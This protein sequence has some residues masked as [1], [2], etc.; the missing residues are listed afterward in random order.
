MCLIFMLNKLLYNRQSLT[1]GCDRCWYS[2]ATNLYVK[3]SIDII[4][5]SVGTQKQLAQ[6]GSALYLLKYKQADT[7]LSRWQPTKDLKEEE[8]SEEQRAVKSSNVY[9]LIHRKHCRMPLTS[10]YFS[11]E[12][13]LRAES[14]V[15]DWA[16]RYV[17][18]CLYLLNCLNGELR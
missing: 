16:T 9:R 3:I 1:F 12:R 15:I 6:L 4:I 13:S 5:G 14:F 7:G 8:P 11:C 2:V 10:Y 18:T 17:R